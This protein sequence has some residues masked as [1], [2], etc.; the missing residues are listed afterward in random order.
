MCA[1]RKGPASEV[2]RARACAIGIGHAIIQA[3]S[4]ILFIYLIPYLKSSKSLWYYD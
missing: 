2:L 4:F 3:Y 1:W